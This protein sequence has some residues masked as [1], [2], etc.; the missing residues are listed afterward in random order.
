MCIGEDAASLSNEAAAA[1]A[2]LPFALPWE[3]EVGFCVGAE[4]LGRIAHG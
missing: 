1:T 4:D 3:G 2:V